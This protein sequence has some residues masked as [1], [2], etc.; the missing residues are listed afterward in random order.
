VTCADLAQRHPPSVHLLR[1]R[2]HLGPRL[3]QRLAA[4]EFPGERNFV[5]AVA[6]SYMTAGKWCQQLV[7]RED[8][9]DLRGWVGRVVLGVWV[10]AALALLVGAGWTEMRHKNP[11]TGDDLS[12]DSGRRVSMN[13]DRK[14]YRP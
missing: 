6:A 2:H 7:V 10:T 5:G 3:G 13:G 12:T 1:Q 8:M 14:L 4:A 9:L 11:K